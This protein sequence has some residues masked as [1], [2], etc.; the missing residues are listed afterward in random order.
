MQGLAAV[1]QSQHVLVASRFE[2]ANAKLL[3]FH[4]QQEEVVSTAA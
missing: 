1:V 4:G 2:G 3:A